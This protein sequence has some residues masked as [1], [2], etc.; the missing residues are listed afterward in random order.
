MLHRFD[1]RQLAPTGN[2]QEVTVV[3]LSKG[4]MLEP[5]CSAQEEIPSRMCFAVALLI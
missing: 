4:R 3:G 5:E 2:L 1:E